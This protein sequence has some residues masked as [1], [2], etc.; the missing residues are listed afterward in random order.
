MGK[1]AKSVTETQVREF[2]PA[3]RVALDDALVAMLKDIPDNQIHALYAAWQL[4]MIERAAELAKA[5][6]ATSRVDFA[7]AAKELYSNDTV[8]K[9]IDS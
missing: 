7:L 9:K 6:F 4:A 5:T 8:D 1:M 3:I 2:L